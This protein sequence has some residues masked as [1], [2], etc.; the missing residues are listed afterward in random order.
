M[1]YLTTY[2]QIKRLLRNGSLAYATIAGMAEV[3]LV[4]SD[5]LEVIKGRE[6][7]G[8]TGPTNYDGGKEGAWYSRK[9]DSMT[10]DGSI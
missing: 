3:Q 4:K 10:F 9:S 7:K 1:E 8:H 2:K 5:L 6:E